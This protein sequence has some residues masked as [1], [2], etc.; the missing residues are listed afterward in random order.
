MVLTVLG[1]VSA[2]YGLLMAALYPAGGFF[3]VW[4]ALGAALVAVT[5]ARRTGAWDRLARWAR[6]LVVGAGV[7]VLVAVGGLC[8]LVATAAVMVPPPGLDCLVVL[9]AGLRPDG[10][11]SEALAYRLD[12]AL[13][14]L[15]DNPQTRCVV[16]GGQGS[17]EVRAEADAMADY[18]TGRGLDEGRLTLEDRSEDTAENVRNSV[19]LLA[20]GETVGIVTNDFHLYRALRI[21][22]RNGLPD[23]AGLAAPSNPLYLPQSVL[24][25][26]A[27]IVK[28]VLAGNM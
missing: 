10:A 7:A 1:A 23:A 24:R 11:P 5:W 14:Y 8:A 6:R 21:A 4:V 3:L 15:E 17:G 2:A 25:E 9:G 27:A 28:D 16:S 26:C 12:A 18:L 20:P 19:V 13:E 22:A